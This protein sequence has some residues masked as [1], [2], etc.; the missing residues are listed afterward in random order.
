MCVCVCV[1]LLRLFIRKCKFNPS[2]HNSEITFRMLHRQQTTNT[3]ASHLMSANI[4]IVG[5]IL[6][7]VNLCTKF[8]NK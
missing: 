4:E 7:L 8:M 2:T 1:D 3:F 5:H 6:I